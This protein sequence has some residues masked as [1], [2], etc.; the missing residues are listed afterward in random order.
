RQAMDER[1]LR[2]AAQPDVEVT[3]FEEGKDL[4]YELKL[5]VLPEIEPIDFQEIELERLVVE[6]GE[7]QVQEALEQLARQQRSTKPLEEARPAA[8]GDVLVVDFK[9][10]VDGEALP[11]MDAEGHHLEL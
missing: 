4:E 1:G 3:S 6:P 11:G 8:T 10:T 9:G 2:P 5:E 7:E